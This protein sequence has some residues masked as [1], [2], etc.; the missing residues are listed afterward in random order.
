M[1]PIGV[2]WPN[3]GGAM[4][5][6]STDFLLAQKFTISTAYVIRKF[7]IL[8]RQTGTHVTMALYSDNAGTPDTLLAKAEGVLLGTANKNEINAVSTVAGGSL[9]IPAGTYWLAAGYDAIT[10][11]AQNTASASRKFVSWSYGNQ[12]P[13][14]FTAAGAVTASVG[15]E[16]NYYLLVT[17]P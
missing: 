1:A 2:G 3:D 13:S 17:S 7:G 16:A 5:N 8:N 9:T 10:S 4:A 15:P 12:L 6:K 14:P 11:V